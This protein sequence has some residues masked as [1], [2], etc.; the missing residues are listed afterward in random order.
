[1]PCKY[2]KNFEN[3]IRPESFDVNRDE[4]ISTSNAIQEFPVALLEED[5]LTVSFQIVDPNADELARLKKQ[6]A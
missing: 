6:L 5:L 3:L 1:M 4:Q 2:R